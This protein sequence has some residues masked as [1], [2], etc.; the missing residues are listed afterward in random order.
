MALPS[1]IQE[2]DETED[3]P[4]DGFGGASNRIEEVVLEDET[5][6]DRAQVLKLSPK[7]NAPAPT[8]A[9]AAVGRRG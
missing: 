1:P 4:E 5:E 8:P 7:V 2:V 3:D 9:P 6:G